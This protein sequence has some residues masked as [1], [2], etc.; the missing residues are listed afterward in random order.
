MTNISTFYNDTNMNQFMFA[1][2]F[3]LT[4]LGINFIETSFSLI[5]KYRTQ[6][7]NLSSESLQ[8]DQVTYYD[9]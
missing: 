4:Y 8:V 3:R 7:Y 5:L 2:D 6:K 9:M 1:V